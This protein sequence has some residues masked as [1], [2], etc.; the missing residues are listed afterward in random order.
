MSTYAGPAAAIEHS[1]PCRAG[2]SSRDVLLLPFSA[3]TP[4]ATRRRRNV[5]AQP[6]WPIAAIPVGA[7][8][9]PDAHSISGIRKSRSNQNPGK[10]RLQPPRTITRSRAEAS[11]EIHR[12][13][14][15][16]GFSL[17][18]GRV[19]PAEIEQSY[20]CPRADVHSISSFHLPKSSENPGLG[21][22]QP[23]TPTA[24]RHPRRATPKR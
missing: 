9:N 19:P 17:D 13:S 3:G 2:P 10:S 14:A 5:R 24:T 11:D 12:K 23:P 18:L 8:T 1:V 21:R 6:G 20:V 16:R 4:T 15:Q 7:P 22:P